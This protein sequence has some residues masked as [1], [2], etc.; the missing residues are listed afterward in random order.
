MPDLNT[1]HWR[2]MTG[3]DLDR[4]AA[5]ALIAFPDHFEGRP[6]FANRLE[7]A[8]RGCFVLAEGD[9]EPMG[10]AISYPWR[11]DSAPP[12][13]ALIDEIPADADVIYLHDLA[14]HPEARG[15]GATREIVERL[16]DQARSR[17]WPA[18]TLVAVNDAAGF[19]AKHGF[20]VRDN[21]A[22]ADKLAGYGSDARYM[23]RPLGPNLKP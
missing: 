13:N 4:V 9:G 7:L 16:A 22:V 1:L 23:I 19:W 2:P 5:I 14:L 18:M 3:A 15:T 20:A 17:G 21:A 10:Y 8:A 11:I 6:M 12:L